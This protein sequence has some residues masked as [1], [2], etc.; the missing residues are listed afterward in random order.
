MKNKEIKKKEGPKLKQ[1]LT[2]S[3]HIHA[4][5]ESPKP[6]EGDNNNKSPNYCSPPKIECKPSSNL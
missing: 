2:E 6:L 5:G 4:N 1:A 3:T